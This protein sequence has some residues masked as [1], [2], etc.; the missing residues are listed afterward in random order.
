[1]KIRFTIDLVDSPLDLK[2]KLK[3]FNFVSLDYLFIIIIIFMKKKK[4]L[5]GAVIVSAHLNPVI[6]DVGHI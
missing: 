2:I 4:G 1:M 6:Y 5:A 3:I